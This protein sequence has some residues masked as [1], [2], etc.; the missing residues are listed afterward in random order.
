MNVEDSGLSQKSKKEHNP[1]QSNSSQ[2]Q[3]ITNNHNNNFF[4]GN[5]G[6]VGPPGPSGPPGPQGPE[7]ECG[8]GGRISILDDRAY[9]EGYICHLANSTEGCPFKQVVIG[10]KY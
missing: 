2:S 9:R 1:S 10:A 7:G 6:D 5:Q 8:Y 3:P 4:S